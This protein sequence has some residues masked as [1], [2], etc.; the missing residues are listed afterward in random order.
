MKPL[1][2]L[3]MVLVAVSQSFS[4]GLYALL[5]AFIV[6]QLE[7]HILIPIIMGRAMKV[8]PVVVI[9]ALLAGAEIAGFVGIVLSVPI[10]VMAQE[11]FNYFSEK[12]SSRT[13]LDI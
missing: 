8:H 13:S 6:Q 9:I 2:V 1:I 10:A 3:V 5:F 11:T 12:K 4:L 7:G